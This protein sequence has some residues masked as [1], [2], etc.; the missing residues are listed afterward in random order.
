[1]FR[2][3][4]H[5]IGVR[6]RCLWNQ[7]RK[8]PHLGRRVLLLGIFSVLILGFIFV[9]SFRILNHFNSIP[10]VGNYLA[11]Q[12]FIMSFVT[13][14]GLVMFSS[15]NSSLSNLY[16]SKD[17]ELLH[18]S[19]VDLS[20]LFLGKFSVSVF[21]S[22]WTAILFGIPIF[23]AYG[24]VYNPPAIFY[25]DLLQVVIC[26]CA[27]AGAIGTLLTM[28]LVYVLPAKRAKDFILILGILLFLVLYLVI[29]TLK[30]E[31][32]VNPDT[33]MDVTEYLTA[34][35]SP[36]LAILPP[37]WAV[38][39][40][41]NKIYKGEIATV[42]PLLLLY[43]TLGFLVVFSLVV[44]RSIYKSGY[45]KAQEGRGRSPKGSKFLDF[46]ARILT[47]PYPSDMKRILEKDIKVFFRDNTQW[48]Q[49]LLIGA[50]IFV[51]I[52]NFSVLPLHKSPVRADYLQGIMSF[53]NL[54]LATFVVSALCVRFVYT[55]VSA[56]G[57]GFW[58]IKS[59]PI[60][61]SRFLWAKFFFYGS[62]LLILG[63]I[64]IVISNILLAVDS[65]MIY[66][67]CFTMMFLIC[68]EVALGIF[69]GSKYAVF[70]YENLASVATGFGAYHY[71][72]FSGGLIAACIVIEAG[73]LH[74]LVMK[75]FRMGVMELSDFIYIVV[76]VSV[77]ALI[78][79][80]VSAVSMRKAIKILNAIEQA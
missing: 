77:V 56:E 55:S 21:E 38:D 1:M 32:L 43:N 19:P 30:P 59:S 76:S 41:W 46:A 25:L 53:L 72:L 57:E 16:L 45:F 29:R 20:V 75:R 61:I 36:S 49:L 63:E 3:I 9:L 64:L 39:V 24:Y 14:F 78:C 31:Q 69:F 54:G 68:A 51:Y 18:A 33:F 35:S 28:L 80:C 26:L 70:R 22:S 79:L 52:Y 58:I 66:L 34:L 67:T 65:F 37:R 62:I 12:M 11:K 47:F 27:I 15:I 7:S 4:K 74:S 2:D 50:L 73:P 8:V 17:L 60:Q 13:I 10:L 44:A 71:M 40:L 6:L 5:I 48:T 42:V 23:S